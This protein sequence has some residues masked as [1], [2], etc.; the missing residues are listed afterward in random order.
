VVVEAEQGGELEA[1]RGLGCEHH[2]AVPGASLGGAGSRRGP[3]RVG[4][5]GLVGTDATIGPRPIGIAV[6]G[7]SAA[8]PLVGSVGS[9]VVVVRVVVRAVVVAVVGAVVVGALGGALGGGT[10][11]GGDRVD[12]R[13][14]VGAGLGAVHQ[15][16]EHPG[17]DE[18]ERDLASG[19]PQPGP[20][21]QRQGP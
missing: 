5:T 1:D 16:H 19:R 3:C 9:A 21:R 11:L 20:H 14:V 7:T 8:R 4:R 2:R 6:V 18:P 17:L 12:D 10:E 15:P 13:G